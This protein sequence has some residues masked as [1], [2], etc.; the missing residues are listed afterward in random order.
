[1]TVVAEEMK[2]RWTTRRGDE[3]ERRRNKIM[4]SVAREIEKERRCGIGRMT[5]MK[6]N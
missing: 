5:G 6:W 3:R 1:L 2:G 4:G